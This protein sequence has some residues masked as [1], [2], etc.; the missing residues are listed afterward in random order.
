MGDA[1]RI[2]EWLVERDLN[3]ISRGEKRIQIEPKVMEVL[4]FL[5]GNSGRVIPRQDILHAVWPGTFVT[6]DV[7]TYSVSEL[8]KAFGDDAKQPHFIQTIPRRGYR[9]IA[10]V[11]RLGLPPDMAASEPST[12][13]PRPRRR[14]R[15]LA[16]GAI[17]IAAIALLL[18]VLQW[19]RPAL[20]EADAILLADFVNTTGDPVFDDTL[21]QA[22]AVHLSQTPFLNIY[23]DE[24]ARETL[25]YMG[26]STNEPLTREAGREICLRRGIKALLAGSI[27][28]LGREYVISLEALNAQTGDVIVREQFEAA[29]KEEVLRTLGRVA[30]NIR[31]GLGESINSIE[32]FDIPLEQATTS[33]LEAF[34]AYSLG[35][36][37]LLSGHTA[38]ALP[39][40]ERAIESDPN[41]ASAYD[42]IAWCYDYLGRRDLAAQS[43]TRAYSLRD[44]VSEYERLSIEAI[45]HTFATGDV[46]KAIEVLE[47]MRAI[48]PRSAPVH[49]TLGGRYASSGQLEKAVDCFREA[50]RISRHPN[51][52]PQLARAFLRLN[53]LKEAK[54]IIAQARAQG[55]DNR[56]LR[57]L[58]YTVAF[59]DGD[60][61]GMAVQAQEALGQPDEYSMLALEAAAAASRG[62][63]HEARRFQQQAI[64][65]AQKKDK[66]E[67]AAGL[68]ADAA[69]REA[70]FGD[71]RKAQEYIGAIKETSN[72]VVLVKNAQ[73]EALCG[74]AD[75]ARL[76]ADRLSEGYPDHTLI[77]TVH[78]PVIRAMIQIRSGDPAQALV[79][80]NAIGGGS[81]PAAL[82]PAYLA[83]EAYLAQGAGA[84]AEGEFRKVLDRG[85]GEDPFSPI[86][87]LAQLGISKARRL[88]GEL[89]KSKESYQRF[90]AL[91]KAADPDLPILQQA[92]IEYSRLKGPAPPSA[93]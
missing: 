81:L 37:R 23:S 35:R 71:C 40:Y 77:Q 14:W 2:G 74:A 73:A 54:E 60:R 24:R 62:H 83:G 15:I 7:L 3:L 20:T 82:W 28:K 63:L 58:C 66:P 29:T 36:K 31:K 21:K 90:F 39:Y 79:S 25:A 1:F 17:A 49:N 86:Y 76:L 84:K 43:A 30:T 22:L 64:E 11:E 6:E 59:L 27:S 85:T 46:N 13:I 67:I 89:A 70:L 61:A 87:I 41:F 34:K 50:I 80:L 57:A 69:R 53:R 45:Y 38:E 93:Y 19:R 75:E 18:W 44:R 92:R 56:D 16:P 55:L 42:D 52:Y 5:A 88:S 12:G 10:P 47:L 68:I 48:Y 8:R 32:K 9:L 26:R 65:V 72:W 78:L 91:L 33:S 51:A 4:I